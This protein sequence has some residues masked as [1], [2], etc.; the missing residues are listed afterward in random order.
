MAD[1]VADW[2]FS[3]LSYR[4]E[5]NQLRSR[6][7]YCKI[8]CVKVFS[9]KTKLIKLAPDFRDHVDTDITWCLDP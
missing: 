3:R 7:L 8:G 2:R 6:K 4:K 5:K 9:L 1:I